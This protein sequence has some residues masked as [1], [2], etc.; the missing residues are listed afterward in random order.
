MMA[1][2]AVV[3]EDVLEVEDRRIDPSS[4]WWI[5]Q[6]LKR[7]LRPLSLLGRRRLEED[8]EGDRRDEGK[9]RK[10]DGCEIPHK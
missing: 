4:P 8:Q 2:E 3:E 9:G 6:S 5:G 10:E 1:A 7:I